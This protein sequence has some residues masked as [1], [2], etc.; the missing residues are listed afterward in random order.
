MLSK[1]NRW[2]RWGK[3]GYYGSGEKNFDMGRI[4]KGLDLGAFFSGSAVV[5]H[6]TPPTPPFR[7]ASRFDNRFAHLTR[8][9][10]CQYERT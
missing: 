5:V 7:Y 2:T 8:R 9:E 6:L 10:R 4:G 3:V 1:S